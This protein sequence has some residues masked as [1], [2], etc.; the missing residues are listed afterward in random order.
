MEIIE[1]HLKYDLLNYLSWYHCFSVFE[2]TASLFKTL[3]IKFRILKKV[4][5]LSIT[6]VFFGLDKRN[7]LIFRYV[8]SY[9]QKSSGETEHWLVF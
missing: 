2:N 5:D 7:F 4:S 6:V 1:A 3:C 9:G 8:F